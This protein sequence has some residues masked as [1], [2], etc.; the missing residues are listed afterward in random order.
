M[1]FTYLTKRLLRRYLPSSVFFKV[2]E[3]SDCGNTAEDRPDDM[4]QRLRSRVQ[5]VEFDL[6]GKH[7]LEFGSG[8]YARL[9][10]WL[11]EAG[12]DRVT[13]VDLHATSLNDSRHRDVLEQD[14]IRLGLDSS[15]ALS[16]IT[17]IADDFLATSPSSPEAL[18]DL[19]I[20]TATLEHVQ[21][22]QL[23]LDKTW[24]WLR[25]GGIASHEID[26]RD[27]LFET[28]FE[29]LTYSDRIWDR[30]L[31]PK[32]GFHLNRWRLPDYLQAME[33]AGFVKIQY[34]TLQQEKEELLKILSRLDRQFRHIDTDSLSITVAHLYGN[35]PT[36]S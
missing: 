35:K 13:M 18:A 29:M 21:D 8:R 7:I 24:Q 28:P 10:L 1:N 25:P 16:R 31:D 26:L 3:Y 27:H 4:F 17:L 12:A 2:M 15:D 20:S 5:E 14:C 19:I 11:L 23:I 6:A 32:G 36:H 34:R 22:P 9:A 33:N 30:W